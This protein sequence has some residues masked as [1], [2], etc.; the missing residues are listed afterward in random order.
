MS[1]ICIGIY[2]A[3]VCSKSH[4]YH[5]KGPCGGE[6]GEIDHRSSVQ[7]AFNKAIRRLMYS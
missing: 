5:I 2:I 6:G 4:L 7:V 1:K 3:S